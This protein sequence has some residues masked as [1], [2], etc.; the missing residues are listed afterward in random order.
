MLISFQKF[1]SLPIN[2]TISFYLRRQICCI[3]FCLFFCSFISKM[4]VFFCT[5]NNKLFSYW[6]SCIVYTQEKKNLCFNTKVLSCFSINGRKFSVA[7]NERWEKKCETNMF[8]FFFVHILAK[9][10]HVLWVHVSSM[11]VCA[12]LLAQSLV[13]FWTRIF[14]SSYECIDH[15]VVCALM[16]QRGCNFKWFHKDGW[17]FIWFD[18]VC[19]CN[20]ACDT[21]NNNN[22][23]TP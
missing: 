13:R 10:N 23:T 11:S 12:R 3:T 7:V 4:C 5:F 16:L 15:I 22:C 2:W 19:I 18:F 8:Y 21:S 6:M 14:H 9:W 17:H 20:D 1:T